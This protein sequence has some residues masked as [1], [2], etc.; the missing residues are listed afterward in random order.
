MPGRRLFDA[1][2]DVLLGEERTLDLE[3]FFAL[4]TIAAGLS[5]LSPFWVSFGPPTAL[6]RFPEWGTGSIL[7]LHGCAHWW[8]L[9]GPEPRVGICRRAALST[10]GLYA[11][12]TLTFMLEPPRLLFVVPIT[13]SIAAAAFLVFLRLRL[14]FHEP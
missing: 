5:V 8:A 1:L 4:T 6:A 13:A 7:F 2:L 11:G 9:R 14:L 12:I 3:R 10:S